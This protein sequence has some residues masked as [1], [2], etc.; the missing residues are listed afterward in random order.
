MF[1]L[2][3]HIIMHQSNFNSLQESCLATNKG[4]CNVY[5]PF[6]LK[7]LSAFVPIL[8]SKKHCILGWYLYGLFSD[9]ALKNR[10]SKEKRKNK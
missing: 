8:F 3:S 1:K 10:F 4:I 5:G 7:F 2:K 6:S 9:L